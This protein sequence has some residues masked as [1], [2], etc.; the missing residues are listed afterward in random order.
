MLVTKIT[1]H[2]QDAKNRLLEQYKGRPLIAGFYDAFNRQVQ[3][4]ED[5]FFALDAGRQLWNGTTSPAIGQQLDNIGEIVGIKRNGLPD[6]EYLLFIFGKIAENNSDTTIPTILNIIGYVFQAQQVVLQEVFP[7]GVSIQVI[8][9][10][11]PPSLYQTAANLVSAA[12]GAGI[13][14]VFVGG[15][16]NVN[17][18]RFEGPGVVGAINGFG[19][20]NDP[21]IGGVFTGLII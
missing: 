6:A 14:L 21:S 8:G 4:I 3:E 16:P 9:T 13:N 5:T 18:F 1:T 10:P 15:S 11:I 2:I 12:L 7:A 17:V 19:D 20:L